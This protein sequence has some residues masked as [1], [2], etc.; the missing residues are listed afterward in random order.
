LLLCPYHGLCAGQIVIACAA[1]AA[2]SIAARL[3]VNA[4]FR[5]NAAAVREA[6]LEFN[7]RYGQSAAA[8]A[9]APATDPLARSIELASPK[10]R[11]S[12]LSVQE[13][14]AVEIAASAGS[15]ATAAPGEV[16][17]GLLHLSGKADDGPAF[18]FSQSE[19]L[20]NPSLCELN[21]MLFDARLSEETIKAFRHGLLARA[22]EASGKAAVLAAATADP[23]P[24]GVVRARDRLKSALADS[25]KF[26][27]ALVVLPYLLCAG[28]AALAFYYIIAFG[29]GMKNAMSQQW[30]QANFISFVLDGFL[31]DPVRCFA[32]TII[33]AALCNARPAPPEVPSCSLLFAVMF[34]Y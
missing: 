15:S 13:E 24:S 4:A 25:V 29:V 17:L 16:E 8:P 12:M 26:Q 30:L 1:A 19:L 32:L 22:A 31:I 23:P 20:Q 14:T 9:P 5:A 28:L 3:M 6:K 10:R 18:E 27:K 34:E 7:R 33:F 21:S 2:I 11:A